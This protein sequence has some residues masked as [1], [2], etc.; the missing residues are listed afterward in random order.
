MQVV[1]AGTERLTRDAWTGAAM[2]ERPELM[3]GIVLFAEFTLTP[4]A[5]F[6]DALR[7]AADHE[8]DSRQVHCGWAFLGADRAPIRASCGLQVIP[9]EPYGDPARFDYVVVVGGKTA[10]MHSYPEAALAFLR[11]A[12]EAGVPLVGLCTGGMVLA[13]A[14]LLEGR[15]CC[16]HFAAQAAFSARYPDIMPVTDANFVVDGAIITCPGSIAAIDVAAYLIKRHCS[17]ARAKKATNYLFMNPDQ[18][19]LYLPDRAYEDRLAGAD[20]VTLDAVRIMELNVSAPVSVAEL[21]RQVNAT[22]SRLTR[23][24][25]SDLGQSPARFW[26][27]L[28]LD[29]ARSMVVD[30]SKSIT[31]VAYETG[32]S[33]SAHFCRL[34]RSAYGTSPHAYRARARR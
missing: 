31:A 24:F 22:P 23:A 14:G 11:T 20:R 29:H 13:E 21:A 34:F 12:H 3:V 25:R 4:L 18:P 7:L 5:G 33:D 9:E 19:R 27:A 8:D 17:R 15:R 26:R 2:P 6:V 1:S 32:F 16:V 30:T 28:R 10:A